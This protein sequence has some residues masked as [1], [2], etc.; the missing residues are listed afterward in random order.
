VLLAD[1][2]GVLLL[3]V[4]MVGERRLVVEELGIDRP[5]AILI[6]ELLAKQVGPQLGN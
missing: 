5:A 4:Q 1:E 2:L 3:L 6:P